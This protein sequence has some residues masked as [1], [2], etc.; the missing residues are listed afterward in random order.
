MTKPIS[1]VLTDDHTMMREG[2][3]RLLEE[4]PGLLV[5]GEAS[6]GKE[7]LTC[8]QRL[9]PDVLILDI[10]MKEMN[11]FEVARSLLAQKKPPAILV[12]TAYDQ[13]T[14]I[15]TMLKTGVKGYW[16]K[17]ARSSSIRQAVYE[18]AQGKITLDPEVQQVLAE[19]ESQSP[20][21][22]LDPLTVRERA[23]LH[24]I[25]QGLRNNE[26][27]QQLHISVKTV[28]AYI[29]SLY[30]KLGVQSRT[31]ATAFVQKYGLLLRSPDDE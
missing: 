12:L 23:V 20:V 24:L 18:V 21:L 7:A 26:I 17:S 1:I 10:S 19:Y 3:R 8:C 15:Q 4:D 11:G 13:V 5:V 16:L 9:H 14:Y 27:A 29:T 25:V 30:S 6:Q 28:E 22:L 31:E 2:T